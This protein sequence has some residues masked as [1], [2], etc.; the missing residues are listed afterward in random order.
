[1][2]ELFQNKVYIGIL[3]FGV[4][5]VDRKGFTFIEA[6]VALAILGI[7]AGVA[8]VV[9]GS[10][11][12]LAQEKACLANMNNVEIASWSNATIY[13]EDVPTSA[14]ALLNGNDSYI[15]EHIVCPSGGVYTAKYDEATG[16]LIISCSVHGEMSII[17]TSKGVVGMHRQNFNS[18]HFNKNEYLNISRDRVRRE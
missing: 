9:F 13:D 15:S 3:N 5:I 4:F 16:K 8:I 7:L 2:F 18:L 1:M 10:I 11:H 12:A 17:Q 6:V 14:N